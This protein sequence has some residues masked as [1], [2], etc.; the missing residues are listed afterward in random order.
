MRQGWP[1]QRGISTRWGNLGSANGEEWCQWSLYTRC[2]TRERKVPSR[3]FEAYKVRVVRIHARH[4]GCLHGILWV[5]HISQ[6]LSWIWVQPFWS[7]HMISCLSSFLILYQLVSPT[8]WEWHLSFSFSEF[9][10]FVDS[11]FSI[12]NV[13]WPKHYSQYHYLS[14]DSGLGQWKWS[15]ISYE[16][17]WNS[18]IHWDTLRPI[19]IVLQG[20]YNRRIFWT[21]GGSFC[22]HGLE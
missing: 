7:D 10:L 8:L 9:E 16:E 4:G 18:M 5:I 2:V 14:F 17:T 22:C 3:C 12:N 19:I 20:S 11:L 6:Y 21:G 15:R 13:V 1:C